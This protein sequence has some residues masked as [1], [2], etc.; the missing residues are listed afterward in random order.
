MN[1]NFDMYKKLL[2]VMEALDQSFYQHLIQ[3]RSMSVQGTQTQT[4]PGRG[5]NP[6]SPWMLH[7][8]ASKLTFWK[9]SMAPPVYVDRF[10]GVDNFKK[11]HV[12]VDFS[13]LLYSSA[14]IGRMLAG[15]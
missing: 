4:S 5:L 2:R 15:T 9:R 7:Q 1:Y 11:S 8:R 6:R 12:G 10:Y 14:N 3:P 13:Q